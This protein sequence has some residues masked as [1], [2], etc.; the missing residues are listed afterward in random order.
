MARRSH[1]S[2]LETA[3][4][5]PHDPDFDRFPPTRPISD[6]GHALPGNYR[7]IVANPFLAI[8]WLFVCFRCTLWLHELNAPPF[9]GA[10]FVIGVG[11]LVVVIFFQYHC[12][13]CGRTGWLGGWSRHSCERVRIRE[14]Y[15]GPRRFRGPEPEIQ[16]LLLLFGFSLVALCYAL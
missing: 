7:R 9:V 2:G 10:R 6:P 4:T 15:S 13:D 11:Y 1:R 3:V 5:R 16:T 14:T 12:L 8:F